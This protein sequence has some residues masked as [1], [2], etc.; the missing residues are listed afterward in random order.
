MKHSEW[1]YLL[2]LLAAELALQGLSAVARAI[3]GRT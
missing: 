2:P 3:F 1:F